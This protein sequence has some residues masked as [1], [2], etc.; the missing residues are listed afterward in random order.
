MSDIW[1]KNQRNIIVISKIPNTGEHTTECTRAS[2][3]KALGHSIWCFKLKHIYTVYHRSWF[4][5]HDANRPMTSAN[6]RQAAFGAKTMQVAVRHS[7]MLSW[8][9][10]VSA[11]PLAVSLGVDEKVSLQVHLQ[12]SNRFATRRVGD[13]SQFVKNS[14]T[15]VIGHHRET[16]IGAAQLQEKGGKKHSH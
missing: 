12:A 4:Q 10:G 7:R 9:Q 13:Q 1:L 11:Q 8:T 15:K 2:F 6:S 14:S 16:V 3:S 5:L